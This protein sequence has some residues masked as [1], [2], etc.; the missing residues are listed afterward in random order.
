M[1]AYFCSEERFVRVTVCFDTPEQKKML[2][3][4][5]DDLVAKYEIT[6]TVLIKRSEGG[7]GEVNIEFEDDYNEQAKPLLEEFAKLTGIEF[8]DSCHVSACECGN[9][10]HV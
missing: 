3:D 4:T 5:M 1:K 8:V 6:P 9:V 7:C 2:C 10:G